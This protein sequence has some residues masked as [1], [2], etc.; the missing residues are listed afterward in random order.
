MEKRRKIQRGKHIKSPNVKI[1]V[2]INSYRGQIRQDTEFKIRHKS[3]I[4]ITQTPQKRNMFALFIAI[5][6]AFMYNVH[7]YACM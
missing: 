6:I 4:T 2:H 5:H 7:L 3:K 1:R